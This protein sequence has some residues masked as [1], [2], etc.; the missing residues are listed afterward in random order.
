MNARAGVHRAKPRAHQLV[1]VAAAREA[2][3]AHVGGHALAL[4]L[5]GHE[6]QQVHVA[7]VAHQRRVRVLAAQPADRHQ[8]RLVV[9]LRQR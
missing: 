1:E 6:P 3:Q 2:A 5:K 4:E 7:L 8:Q 9:G